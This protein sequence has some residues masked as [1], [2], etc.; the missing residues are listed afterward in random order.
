MLLKAF[1][2]DLLQLCFVVKMVII[3]KPSIFL[4]LVLI[5]TC[6]FPFASYF[7]EASYAVATAF[8]DMIYHKFPKDTAFGVLFRGLISKCPVF[9]W[10]KACN[11]AGLIKKKGC[12]Y[13]LGYFAHCNWTQA[14][15]KHFVHLR[16]Y[17]NPILC[18]LLYF[19]LAVF[20]N[21]S[22]GSHTLSFCSRYACF[23]IFTKYSCWV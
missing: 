10:C 4:E 21:Y 6:H 18:H 7:L 20:E 9:P 11:P 23:S 8:I 16:F 19:L 22:K 17:C 5:Q 1:S 3:K 12:I 2:T 13:Y 14:T 15:V